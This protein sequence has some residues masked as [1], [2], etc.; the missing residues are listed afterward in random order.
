MLHLE[1][2]PSRRS[3]PALPCAAVPSLVPAC[4]WGRRKTTHRGFTQVIPAEALA[5]ISPTASRGWD[6]YCSAATATRD[7]PDCLLGPPSLNTH[8][9]IGIKALFP[10]KWNTPQLHP[11]R[12]NPI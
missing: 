12:F 1:D 9:Q 4:A 11:V 5:G 3:V 6:A 2:G 7:P 8:G 10:L